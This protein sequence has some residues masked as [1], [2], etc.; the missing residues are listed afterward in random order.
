LTVLEEVNEWN[1]I[2][3]VVVSPMDLSN[4]LLDL[5]QSMILVIVDWTHG[6]KDAVF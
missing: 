6:C 1:P 3:Y 2:G 4:S 5:E